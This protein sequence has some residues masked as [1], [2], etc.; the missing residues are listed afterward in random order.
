MICNTTDSDSYCFLVNA[1]MNSS[2][3]FG[4]NTHVFFIRADYAMQ[5]NQD[6]AQSARLM[7]NLI[8]GQVLRFAKAR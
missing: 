4:F 3:N 6:S 2:R 7:N 8:R 5:C 1:Y